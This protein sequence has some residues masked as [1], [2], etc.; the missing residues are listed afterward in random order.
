MRDVGISHDQAMIANHGFHAAASGAFADGHGFVNT[1]VFA[2][3]G[4][5]IFTAKFQV[6]RI[7]A[8]DGAWEY[9]GASANGGAAVN[10]DVIT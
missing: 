2:N 7:A 5:A 9:D 8:D 6:L 10:R 3:D 1:A 4:F